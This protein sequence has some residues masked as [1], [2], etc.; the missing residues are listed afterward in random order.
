MKGMRFGFALALCV[1]SVGSVAAQPVDTDVRL[2]RATG[3]STYVHRPEGA[4]CVGAAVIY[5]TTHTSNQGA[6]VTPVANGAACSLGDKI[7]LGGTNRFICSIEVEFFTLAAAT[8]FDAT[9]RLYTDCSTSGAANSP[10][11]NGTGT[12]IPGSTVTVTGITPPGVLGTIFSVVFPYGNL[13]LSGEVDNTISVSITPSRSDVLWRINETPT[14]GSIPAGE[15]ATSFVERCGSTG[16]NNGCSRN[17]GVNNNFAIRILGE[18]AS[19][20][21][22]LDIEVER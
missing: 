17:F 12:L 22:L 20:V 3:V 10:C 8:P 21:E 1:A 13:D 7:V 9:M 16:T 4:N 5:D 2:G 6:E 11:G 18:A 15:P 19:P 14:T